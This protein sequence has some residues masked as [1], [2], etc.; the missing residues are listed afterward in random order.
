MIL[1]DKSQ[2]GLYCPW[3]LECPASLSLSI[4]W[5]PVYTFHFLYYLLGIVI[6]KENV[7]VIPKLFPSQ[8]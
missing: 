7:L 6:V 1:Y 8:L 2:E 5:T 4:F 3:S